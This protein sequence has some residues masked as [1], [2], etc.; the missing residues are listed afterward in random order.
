MTSVVNASGFWKTMNN[1][2]NRFSFTEMLYSAF[3]SKTAFQG[4]SEWRQ[5]FDK[6]M[7]GAFSRDESNNSTHG[8]VRTQEKSQDITISTPKSNEAVYSQEQVR[9]QH[10]EVLQAVTEK[11][12]AV[13]NDNRYAGLLDKLQTDTEFAI[14]PVKQDT[15]MVNGKDTGDISSNYCWEMLR[16]KLFNKK[17]DRI[18]I[19]LA[20]HGI[21]IYL[22]NNH[23]A[24]ESANS[25]LNSVLSA[26]SH[27][28]YAI[29]EIKINGI[30]LK[31][32]RG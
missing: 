18:H 6:L 2:I 31:N 24:E 5:V 14:N 27:T 11:D 28:E 25:I 3:D 4:E 29:I 1:V 22:R 30:T 10:Y 21:K 19:V 17:M 12:I 13:V 7:M 32:N 26:I 9:Q 23:E 20:E 15:D 16:K 8:M